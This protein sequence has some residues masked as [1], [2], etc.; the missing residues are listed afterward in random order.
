MILKYASIYHN[1]IRAEELS[2]LKSCLFVFSSASGVNGNKNIIVV[3]LYMKK[4]LSQ[5]VF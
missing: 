5:L 2:G 4:L 1:A 3:K